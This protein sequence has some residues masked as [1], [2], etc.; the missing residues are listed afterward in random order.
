[1]V[2]RLFVQMDFGS[3]S[4]CATTADDL[5][6]QALSILADEDA[7]LGT[8]DTVVTFLQGKNPGAARQLIHPGFLPQGPRFNGKTRF[9]RSV[10][11][12]D[13]AKHW[14]TLYLE[15]LADLVQATVSPSFALSRYAETWL[16]PS[17]FDR[18]LSL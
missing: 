4:S 18:W 5:P 2:L 8:I 15:N 6:E 7:Y 9:S 3:L 12:E 10:S 11:I 1:M 17:S 13:R 16:T 14:G